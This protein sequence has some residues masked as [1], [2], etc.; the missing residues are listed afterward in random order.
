MNHLLNRRAF[1][2]AT[3]AT[4]AIATTM[5]SDPVLFASSLGGGNAQHESGPVV[6]WTTDGVQPNDLVMMVGGSLSGVKDALVWRLPDNSVE[7]PSTSLPTAPSD[8]LNIKTLQANENSFK[9]QLPSNW[10]QGVYGV[11][12]HG[13]ATVVL[14]RPQLWFVQPTTLLPGLIANEVAAGVEVQIIGKDLLLPNESGSA[15]IAIRPAGGSWQQLRPGKAER[16]SLLAIL[17]ATLPAGEYE[18]AVHN[19]SGGQYGWSTPIAFNVKQPERW[20]Q[21][22][23]N[24]REH[25]AA[26]DDIHDDTA[27]IRK[28][29]A[30]A[31][32]NGGG[33]VHF[34][35]GTYRLD[36]FIVLPPRVVLRG[37]NRDA[38]ILKWPENM[39]TDIKD[40]Q[41]AAIYTCSQFGI[42]NLTI[43]AR[44]FD[45]TL[46]DLSYENIRSNP[47][48]KELIPY[49]KPWSRYRDIFVRHVRF[50]QWLDAG[51]PAITQDIALDSRF[52]KE[53]QCFNFRLSACQNFEVSGCIFQ[54]GS[55]QFQG[56]RN[57]RITNNSFSNSMNYCW[58]QLGGGAHHLVCTDNDI[59]ASSSFGY[60]SIGLQYV[61]V[62]NNI[63][64]NFVRGEREGMTLDISAMPS[65]RSLAE[66]CGSPVAINNA[67]GNITM[68]FAPAGA[69]L[70][71]E[72]FLTGFVP[73]IFRGGTATYYPSPDT[74][75]TIQSCL[76][77][78]NTEDAVT[79]EKPWHN[80]AGIK[81]QGM[82]ILLEPRKNK[83]G[84]DAWVGFINSVGA[85]SLTATPDSKWLPN[86]FVGDVVL[87]L[88]GKGAG[89]YRRIVANNESEVSLDRPWDVMPEHGEAIGIWAVSRHFIFYK[90]QGYDTSDFGQLYGSGYDFVMDSCHTERNQGTWGQMGWF[91]QFRNNDSFYGYSYHKGIGPRGP[92]PEGNAPYAMMGLTGDSL[93]LTKFGSIQY[94]QFPGGTAIMVDKLLGKK[95]PCGLATVIRRNHL[96][97]NQR[98]TLG[99]GNG[100][101]PIRFIDAV[102]DNNLIEHSEVGIEIGANA[103]GV[104]AAG[105]R[106]SDVK[107]P[108]TSN[109][110]GSLMVIK[111]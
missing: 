105:N 69:P 45:N 88:T 34:P 64:R 31:E 28:V 57:A 22:I 81:P 73:G 1:L 32:A 95:I 58:T 98:I 70:N 40:F 4:T 13:G 7:E 11:Q 87:V 77:L 101:I 39:P 42:E 38:T 65:M 79:I 106:F 89:Q 27:V 91:V 62:A 60:G 78:D 90:C 52:Y 63:T 18:I 16:Y 93:R 94:P 3:A 107:K 33:I 20:P 84:T 104:L 50:Q 110:E 43:I 103:K 47:N 49:V 59:T 46:M 83:H 25:G 53:D 111:S 41:R 74:Q 14:N 24:V 80:S 56:M 17:P 108:Y 10:K 5:W 100:D 96:M 71:E 48:A 6:F 36:G 72:G 30:E 15:S 9:F 55:N 85:S 67:D 23:W 35:W 37:E 8:A 51:R 61:Y 54:G 92:T 12:I 66:Y 102:I 2:Q 68:K 99:G 82:R 97:W 86:E 26:G 76:I 75:D 44:N 21:K 29:L 109:R 19:G